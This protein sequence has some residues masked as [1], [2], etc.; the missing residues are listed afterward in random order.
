MT[1]FTGSNKTKSLRVLIHQRA[2]YKLRAFPENSGMGPRQVT[3]FN[4]AEL[5]LYGKVD[6]NGDAVVIDPQFLKGSR[7]ARGT[8]ASVVLLDFV[9]DM[10]Q[11]FQGYFTK[12]CRLRTIFLED[13][14][15]SVPNAVQGYTSPRRLYNEWLYEMTIVFNEVFLKDRNLNDKTLD[16]KD[17]AN[18]F[19][20]FA[21]LLGEEFPISFT[22][23][24]RSRNSSVFNS[25]IAVDIA[26]LDT[27]EDSLKEQFF[28]N[29]PN[30]EF[31][32]NAAMQTGF[33]V[34]KNAPWILVADLASPATITYLKNYD[35]STPNQVFSSKYLKTHE[36]ELD[37]LKQGLVQGYNEF[38]N[39]HP[40]SKQLVVCN[41]NT[42][43][44]IVN[45]HNTN[46][47]SINNNYSNNTWVNYYNKLRNIEERKPY[48][49]P[50]LE[51]ITKN[52]SFYEKTFDMKEAIGYVNEQYRSIYITKKGGLNDV[53]TVQRR[54]KRKSLFGE[55]A[56][57]TG[58][59]DGGISGY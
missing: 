54:K 46:I 11:D 52:A 6:T 33:S 15:L 49:T 14:F 27:S 23:W 9:A 35:L 55:V 25:G 5:N 53:I 37:L 19:L 40:Y 44:N 7:Y 29:S 38:V 59:N 28:L 32:L 2:R 17:Y 43:S 48:N 21:E 45:R 39:K 4:F 16:F 18:Y 26:G 41:S 13:P 36:F 30:Y 3:D 47:N 24:H 58:G 10:F 8:Q 50:D 56:S 34:T 51:R 20:K 1:T 12:A 31:F 42:T 57:T 22:G